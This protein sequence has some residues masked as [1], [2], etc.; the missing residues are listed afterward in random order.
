MHNV[1]YV[2]M[3]TI[4]MTDY[5]HSRTYTGCVM[6]KITKFGLLHTLDIMHVIHIVIH[7]YGVLSVTKLCFQGYLINYDVTL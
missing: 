2:C 6:R 5:M 7:F 4:H 3:I 1:M